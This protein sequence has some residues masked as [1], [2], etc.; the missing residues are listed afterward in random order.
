MLV[1]SVISITHL[2]HASKPPKMFNPDTNIQTLLDLM[3]NY[4]SQGIPQLPDDYKPDAP[5]PSKIPDTRPTV[6]WEIP[7]QP[8]MH[9]N[10]PTTREKPLSTARKYQHP[11]ARRFH[12]PPQSMLRRRLIGKFRRNPNRHQLAWKSRPQLLLVLRLLVT[13]PRRRP[14]GLPSLNVI[15]TFQ[16]RHFTG[17]LQTEYQTIRS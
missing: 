7:T 6:H 9:R 16:S 4:S 11:P 3:A 14:R 1:A 17:L 8:S 13:E 5:P 15:W 10:S 2:R 12:R